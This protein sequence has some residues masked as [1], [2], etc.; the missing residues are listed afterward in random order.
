MKTNKTNRF[1]IFS[2][3]VASSLALILGSGSVYADSNITNTECGTSGNCTDIKGDLTFKFGTGETTQISE[4]L[5]TVTFSTSTTQ[6]DLKDTNFEGQAFD[7]PNSTMTINFNGQ[8]SKTFKLTA[9]QAEFKGK[10]QVFG[11]GTGNN[12]TGTFKHGMTGE[13]N[14]GPDKNLSNAN[15]TLIFGNDSSMEP[16]KET[17]EKVSMQNQEE[18]KSL[19]G[20]IFIRSGQNATNT[21][22]FKEDFK[23]QKIWTIEGKS[24]V[25]FEKNATMESR[26]EII[27]AGWY[28][29][30]NTANATFT[31]KGEKNS[32]KNTRGDGGG[33]AIQANANQGGGKKA[34][35]T[36]NFQGSNSTNTIEGNIIATA[37]LNNG[38][39]EGSNTITFDKETATNEIK[40]NINTQGNTNSKNNIT[41][42]GKTSNTIT[43]NI[44]TSAGNA[45]V[46]FEVGEESTNAINTIT[47][48]INTTSGK[49][50]IAFNKPTTQA[51]GSESE[52]A[53]SGGSESTGS[54]DSGS[55]VSR[56]GEGS[57]GDTQTPSNTITGNV[58]ANAAT[59]DIS[60]NTDGN[61]KIK[62]WIRA[63]GGATAQNKITFTGTGT[64]EIEGKIS[65]EWTNR[66]SNNTNTIT[67][68]NHSGNNKIIGDIINNAQTNTIT[69]SSDRLNSSNTTIQGNISV[70]GGGVATNTIT[71]QS[72]GANKII[73]NITTNGIGDSSRN[74]NNIY[75]SG[76]V[77]AADSK[78][79]TAP[80]EILNN[81]SFF[82]GN[83]TTNGKNNSTNIV[84][85]DSIWLPSNYKELISNASNANNAKLE[86]DGAAILNVETGTIK[87]NFG[88]T[89]IVLRTSSATALNTLGTSMFNVIN[90][91]NSG[92]V[93]IVVQ[94][95]VNVGA[96]VT[97]GGK[98]EG[99]N[100]IWAGTQHLGEVTFIFA[101]NHNSGATPLALE[102]NS[103]NPIQDNF[104]SEST[105]V[106]DTNSKV[107]GITYQDGV[108]LT[109]KDRVVKINS[110]NRSFVEVYKDYFSNIADNGLL[111]LKTDRKNSSNV[112]TDTIS[113][114]GLA[115]GD[116]SEL[117]SSTTE[118]EKEKATTTYNYNVTL[119]KGS[120]FVGNIKLQEN[121]NVALTMEEG[122][123]LLTDTAHLKIA[124]LMI[125][126]SKGV[127][128]N[129]FLLGTFAQSNTIIDIASMGNDLGD[130]ATREDFRLLEIGK[131]SMQ[132]QQVESTSANGLQGNGAIFRVYMKSNA[133][134]DKATLA[135]IKAQTNMQKQEMEAQDTQTSTDG[136]Y[137]HIYS[138]RIL[139]LSGNTATKSNEDNSNQVNYIQVI[140]D[141]KTNFSSIKYHGGGTEKE[142]NIAVATVKGTNDQQVAKFEGATQIQGFDVIG[143]TLTTATTDQYGKIKSATETSSTDTMN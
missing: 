78:K 118:E 105:D 30:K 21:I 68:N 93:N 76:K 44:N 124:N 70:E 122:S 81:L 136:R 39:P 100:Y 75:I 38:A 101:N 17:S 112:Q 20:G 58:V 106:S 65:A 16:S 126:N 55:A 7:F 67:F 130:L 108:K 140:A 2:P 41:F 104:S 138:D 97:Y 90:S 131:A 109:L 40:G 32:I 33:I 66:S 114:K 6:V 60:F 125:K 111:T 22:T 83:I 23:T 27:Y 54:G 92:K 52:S 137:G 35:N 139:I 42:K 5:K 115:L 123:K 24:T 46:T 117:G 89:N 31:F 99:D 8:S 91:G 127:D 88:T 120:A 53:E 141:G 72:Q 69:T 143:T 94:G 10:L 116:L 50:T 19:N 4:D 87:N 51:S 12:F 61:N 71:L 135:G 82:A 80:S 134:Q 49:T 128:T 96:N 25:T 47:G 77:S 14:I 103:S 26:D 110:Q 142:G 18:P 119:E 29:D 74:S 43:G 62:G 63:H 86:Q 64:N 84:F 45:K 113:I 48:N 9:E 73:G 133:D 57:S 59:N 3:V 95:Q 102:S 79:T 34:S 28:Q 107:L 37:N 15:T 11:G 13:I 85:E 121:S 129:E 132:E 1:K 36:L 98:L 56:N